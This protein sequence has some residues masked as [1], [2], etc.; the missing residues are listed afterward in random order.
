MVASDTVQGNVTLRLNDVPWDQA[1]DIVLKSKGLAKRQEGN[2]VRIGPLAEVQKM[3]QQELEANRKVEELVPL[4]TELIPIKYAR[5]SDVLAILQGGLSASQSSTAKQS[6]GDVAETGQS[7]S[8]VAKEANTDSILSERGAVTMDDRTNTLL[9]KDTAANIDK[10]R[11]LVAALDVPVRQVMI[12]S[13]IVVANDNFTRN[14]GA[15]LT[16][17]RV[18]APTSTTGFDDKGTINNTGGSLTFMNSLVD[19]AAAT[20]Q[21]RLGATILRAGGTL[22]DLELSAGQLEGESEILSNPRLLTSDGT[23]AVIKQGTQIPYQVTQAAGSGSSGGTT[24]IKWKDAVLMLEVTPHIA[25]D[26]NVVLELKITKDSVGDIF[27]STNGNQNPVIDTKEVQTNVQ[28]ADG[29]TVVLGGVYEDERNKNTDKI[30]WLS[31]IPGLGYLFQRKADVQKKRELLVFIT[32][33]I[34]RQALTAQK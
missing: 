22:L 23:K 16:A 32:P 21:G 10:V 6:S 26:D 30:P 2:V 1:L 20:P 34:V 33:K 4:I 5:A 19:L 9:V 24:T 13:R 29:D 3:E 18:G 14:L 28:V 15:K 17:N 7:S 8:Q 25:P 11:E 27:T 31:D 12:E